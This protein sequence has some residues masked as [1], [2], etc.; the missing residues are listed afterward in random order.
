MLNEDMFR[1]NEPYQKHQIR[2]KLTEFPFRG[3]VCQ[4]KVTF[5]ERLVQRSM[6]DALIDG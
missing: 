5:L 2:P 4:V 1:N 3:V 6:T